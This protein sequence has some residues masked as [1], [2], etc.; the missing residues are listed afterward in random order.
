MGSLKEQQL[1]NQMRTM[2]I[3][4]KLIAADHILDVEYQGAKSQKEVKHK[5][6]SEL[7]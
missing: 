3:K 5:I 4:L 1:H 6:T 2:T 7:K